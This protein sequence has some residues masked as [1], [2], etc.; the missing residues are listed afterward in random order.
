MYE[1]LEPRLIWLLAPDK[2]KIVIL[3]FAF[4]HSFHFHLFN[5]SLQH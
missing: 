2:N 4:P 5:L 1:G 3:E